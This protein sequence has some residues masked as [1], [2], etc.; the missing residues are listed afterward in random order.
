MKRRNASS[1]VNHNRAFYRDCGNPAVLSAWLVDR[2]LCVSGT[3]GYA[4]RTLLR[5]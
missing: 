4:K 1:S 5:P 2:K 3:A